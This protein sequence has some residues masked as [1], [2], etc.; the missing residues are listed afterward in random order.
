MSFAA[1]LKRLETL[2]NPYPGLRP[3]ETSEAALFFGREAHTS[4]L[5][6]RLEQNCFL[7]VIGVSGSGKSSLVRAGLIPALRRGSLAGS[8]LHW[9]IVV[10]RPAGSPLSSLAASLQEAQFDPSPLRNSSYGLIQIGQQRQRDESLLIIVDQ[11]EEIFRY[12]DRNPLTNEARIMREQAAAEANDFVQLLLAASRYEP[13]VYVV[14][15]MRS[16]YLGDCAEFRDLPETLNEGQYLI[17]R[18]TR[19]QRRQAIIY[20]LRGAEIEPALLERMLNDAGDQ[21]DQLPILQHALMRTWS[22]WGG[23]DFSRRGLSIRRGERKIRVSDYEAIGGFDRSIDQH[24]NELLARTRREFAEVIFK[25]LT[26]RARNQQE[27]RDPSTLSDLWHLCGAKTDRE[28]ADVTSVIELFRQRDSTFLLPRDCN[29][30]PESYIDIAHESLIRQ[31]RIL[32]EEWMPEEAKSAKT[33]LNLLER[34]RNW[35]AGKAS[36]LTG[37]DLADARQWREQGNHTDTWAKHYADEAALVDVAKFIKSSGEAE[38]TETERAFELYKRELDIAREIQQQLT[39][40][41]IPDVSFAQVKGVTHPCGAVGGDF[42]DLVYTEDSLTLVVV[43]V[44]GKGIAAALLASTLQGIIYAQLVR[45]PPLSDVIASVN[46]F[47][48]ERLSRGG[49]F[50]TLV[51]ARLTADGSMELANAGH[52]SPLVISGTTVESIQGGNMPVGLIAA[53][54]FQTVKLKL[55]ARDQLLIVTDGVIEAANA[56]DEYFGEERLRLT[57]LGGFAGI[58]HAL[59]DFCGSIRP[60]DDL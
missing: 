57:A 46:S 29:L 58:E 60:C 35:K 40:V 27:R 54:E 32:R 11:F 51:M 36:L 52:V 24:A 33:F 25:R 1:V 20:P 48:C 47:M 49:R 6:R 31:W 12:K 19:E 16:D 38:S 42:F 39:S 10:T 23:F 8:G 17:P 59:A 13:P 21:P 5:V 45:E 9:R 34:A 50:A 2:E 15:T 28:R 3:F 53:A 43:D 26:A 22:H 14:V 44:S 4:D 7:A 18:M 41:A 37:L 30:Q 55:K 56:E